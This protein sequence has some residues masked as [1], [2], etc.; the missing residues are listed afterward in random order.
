MSGP[1]LTGVPDP[2]EELL[3]GIDSEQRDAVIRIWKYGWLTC[4]EMV[5]AQT[6]PQDPISELLANTVSQHELF[7][8]YQQAGF[9]PQQALHLLSVSILGA[10]LAP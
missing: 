1:D 7:T 6:G 8:S 5:I 4:R 9:N 2:P 10:M 3:A